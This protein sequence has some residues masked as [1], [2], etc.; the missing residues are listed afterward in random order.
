[1]RY[2]GSWGNIL[3]DPTMAARFESF[4]REA[5]ARGGTK[6]LS[7]TSPGA[8]FVTPLIPRLVIEGNTDPNVLVQ[9]WVLPR[10]RERILQARAREEPLGDYEVRSDSQGRFR[11]LVTFPGPGLYTLQVYT[12]AGT[13]GLPHQEWLSVLYA[14]QGT[15]LPGSGGGLLGSGAGP[16]LSVEVPRVT[17][18]TTFW[19]VGQTAPGA[20]VSVNGSL[21]FVDQNGSFS[22]TVTLPGEGRHRVLVEAWDAAGKTTTVEKEVMVDLTAPFGT[23]KF[24]LTTDQAKVELSGQTEP[25]TLVTVG[26]EQSIAGADGSFRITVGLG[27]GNNRFTAIFTDSVGNSFRQDFTITRKDREKIIKLVIAKTTAIVDGQARTLDVAPQIFQERTFVPLRFI[28]EA[29]G[30]EVDWRP[31]NSTAVYR[32]NGIEVAISIGSYTA[33]VNGKPYV[34]ETPARLVQSRTLV[35]LRFIMESLGARV[36]YDPAT[37][38]ITITR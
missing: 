17:N 4:V 3:A 36:D 22:A 25:G 6:G 20:T 28:G 15:G 19:A 23:I 29:L 1:M 10:T 16:A 30:A 12:S 18:Q 21:A 37:R 27:T 31:A 32:L 9:I 38:S 33:L 35:P 26:L 34:L 11:S 24:P 13:N 8:E 2:D 5:V 7:V 14:A